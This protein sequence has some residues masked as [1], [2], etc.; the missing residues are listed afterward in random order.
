MLKIL[1]EPHCIPIIR[2]PHLCNS[3]VAMPNTVSYPQ[4]MSATVTET[5]F[6]VSGFIFAL[7][8]IMFIKF[9][10]MLRI[11]ILERTRGP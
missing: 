9:F 8:E 11:W 2:L 4:F 7:H 3:L 6:I 1:E 10:Q 5:L